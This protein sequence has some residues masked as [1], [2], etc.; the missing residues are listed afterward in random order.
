MSGLYELQDFRIPRIIS[1]ADLTELSQSKPSLPWFLLQGSRLNTLRMETL[2]ALQ[3]IYKQNFFSIYFPSEPRGFPAS[4]RLSLG[5]NCI[6][7][8]RSWRKRPNSSRRDKRGT[9]FLPQFK[10]IASLLKSSACTQVSHGV[11]T[12]RLTKLPSFRTAARAT[13]W[14]LDFSVFRISSARCRAALRD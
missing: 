10:Y 1:K 6:P 9:D 14:V 4:W 7:Y 3:R 2:E 8:Q 5:G 13:V 12:V 11:I